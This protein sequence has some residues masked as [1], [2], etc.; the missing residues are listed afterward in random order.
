MLF[1]ST[2]NTFVCLLLHF[3]LSYSLSIFSSDCFKLCC[4]ILDSLSTV[5][6]MT[7]P[8]DITTNKAHVP[9]DFLLFEINHLN[10]TVMLFFK[11]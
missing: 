11:R 2:S 3:G 4:Q 9:P 6:C 8:N 1:R 7:F 10:E 5:Y